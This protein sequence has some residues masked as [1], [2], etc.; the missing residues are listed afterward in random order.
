MAANEVAIGDGDNVQTHG[1]AGDE[2]DSSE[3][4]DDNVRDE[5]GW[6]AADDAGGSYNAADDSNVDVE[7]LDNDYEAPDNNVEAPNNDVE[8]PSTDKETPQNV[9]IGE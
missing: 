6:G 8:A 5:E 7:A 3:A 1:G 9:I 4:L 2:T